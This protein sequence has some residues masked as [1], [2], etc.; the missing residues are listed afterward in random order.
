MY[1]NMY[2]HHLTNAVRVD[3]EVGLARVFYPAG[4]SRVFIVKD[5]DRLKAHLLSHSIRH[6]DKRGATP[7]PL[8]RMEGVEAG[9]NAP[10]SEHN[11]S[12]AKLSEKAQA[13]LD[14]VIAQFQSGDLSPISHAVRLQLDPDA[15]ASKWTLSNRV[16]AYV[17][18]GSLDCRG[19]RQWQTVGRQVKKGSH[20]AYILRPRLV[21]KTNAAGEEEQRLIGFATVAVFSADDTEGDPLPGYTPNEMPP[22]AD[23]AVKLGIDVDYQP[24]PP[25]VYGAYSPGKDAIRLATHDEATFFHEL[26]HAA[27][28]RV[29]GQLKGGQHE[30]QETVAEFTAAVLMELYGIRDHSGNAWHYISIYAADPLV[31]ITKALATVEKVLAF[32]LA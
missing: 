31:A 19:Y 13:S 16:L 17:Q 6:F 20:S 15:P 24:L 26:A 12:S 1:P 2:P 28:K 29:D 32:L 7:P 11:G 25:G 18:T 23:L 3:L 9:Q 27:H 14:K 5:G 30:D 10:A 22:L 4:N 21:K 8:N